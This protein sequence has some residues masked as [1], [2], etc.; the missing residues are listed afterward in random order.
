MS[1]KDWLERTESR[2]REI[3]RNL[4][5]EQ[6]GP[7]FPNIQKEYW[8]TEKNII[9]VWSLQSSVQGSWVKLQDKSLNNCGEDS[10]TVI[11][12]I[13]VSK[14]ASSS[15]YLHW[16]CRSG[17]H[18]HFNGLSD[19]VKLWRQQQQD[20]CCFI[21]RTLTSQTTRRLGFLMIKRTQLHVMLLWIINSGYRLLYD[22][23]WTNSSFISSHVQNHRFATHH[24]GEFH[25]SQLT[26]SSHWQ[27]FLLRHCPVPPYLCERVLTIHLSLSTNSSTWSTLCLL[28]ST[29]FRLHLLAPSYS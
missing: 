16:T 10:A 12:Y 21:F 25:F 15:K 26:I 22:L 27:V 20:Q 23:R 4:I 7:V 14:Y 2:Q 9:Q 17:R 18:M 19:N 24:L 13:L 6:K 11:L 1:G 28:T 29:V 5:P 3:G 8:V